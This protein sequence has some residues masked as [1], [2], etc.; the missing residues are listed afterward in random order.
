MHALNRSWIKHRAQVARSLLR[1]I[2]AIAGRRLNVFK[3]SSNRRIW[4]ILCRNGWQYVFWFDRTRFALRP[5][6]HWAV[7][8][9]CPL[10]VMSCPILLVKFTFHN[11]PQPYSKFICAMACSQMWPALISSGEAHV[12]PFTC[13][14]WFQKS[15]TFGRGRR[16]K[17]A[18]GRN[19]IW[20]EHWKHWIAFVFVI[21]AFRAPLLQ[22]D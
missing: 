13:F 2:S 11:I 4:D 9:Q 10:W 5:Q 21:P 22:G 7:K 16:K 1:P 20:I 14:S 19:L 12:C 6:L 8:L 15:E 18:E 17:L 3:L